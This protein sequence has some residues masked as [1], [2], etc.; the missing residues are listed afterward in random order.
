MFFFIRISFTI[1]CKYKCDEEMPNESL[2]QILF[3]RL[4][5]SVVLLLL[6]Y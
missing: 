6:I 3:I 4:Y 5:L 1:K 2:I